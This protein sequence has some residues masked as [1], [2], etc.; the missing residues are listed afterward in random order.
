MTTLESEP[1]KAAPNL[2][3]SSP[4]RV[5]LGGIA[6]CLLSIAAACI[7]E[8]EQG[9]TTSANGR[10]RAEPI[11]V[12]HAD[13]GVIARVH[14]KVGSDVQ[15]GQVLLSLDTRSIDSQLAGLRTQSEAN[16]M[17]RLGLQ[18]EA[19]A[20]SAL[21]RQSS[22]RGRIAGLQSQLADI[23]QEGLGLQVRIAMAEQERKRM[24]IRTPV[25]GQISSLAT[26]MDGSALVANAS[27]ATVLPSIDRILLET[28]WP[29][30]ISANAKTGQA[31]RIWPSGA[32]SFETPMRGAV[33]AMSPEEMDAQ[34][35][36]GSSQKVRIAVNLAGTAIDQQTSQ[37]AERRFTV[38]LVTR[39]LSLLE[40]LVSPFGPLP[41]AA[42][43]KP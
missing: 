29:E 17:R 30:A 27:V 5:G 24:E 6:F 11:I 25:S 38:Q 8:I 28:I 41:A 18:Q 37:I 34:R 22:Q 33:E 23:E 16:K 13:G 1:S 12:R 4:I 9:P 35:G 43:L 21:D 15:A 40:H 19:D 36:T 10:V 14:V 42:S 39:K 7:I 20:L 32:M 2:D 31:A 3:L 26:V